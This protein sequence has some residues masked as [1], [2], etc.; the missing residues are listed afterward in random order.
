MAGQVLHILMQ[1]W[2]CRRCC[3]HL[4][5]SPLGPGQQHKV[6]LIP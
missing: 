1:L 4:L 2:C 3:L 5:P 6:V